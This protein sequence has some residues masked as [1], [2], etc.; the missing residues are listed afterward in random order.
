LL[1]S[2]PFAKI[3]VKDVADEC[4]ISR[5]SFYYHFQDLP[6]LL[7]EIVKDEMDRIIENYPSVETQEECFA[8][9][10][11]F[12]LANKRAAYHIY[13]SVNRD[14]FEQYLWK[15]CAH[16]VQTYLRPLFDSYGVADTD[17]GIIERYYC[18]AIFGQVSGWLAGGMQENIAE[19]NRR[20]CV[21]KKG[22]LEELLA[23]SA[24][25]A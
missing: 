15:V 21:L 25:K 23:R 19:D 18:R 16:A 10:A 8:V 4:G 14:I 2:K 5:N 24:G 6:A 11:E 7:E 17:R 13:H 22:M 9:A 1:D 12:A 3:T 20:L